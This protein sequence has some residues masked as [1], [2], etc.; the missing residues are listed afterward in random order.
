[1]RKA[2]PASATT[3]AANSS[4]SPSSSLRSE[5]HT[6][7]LQ[8]LTNIVCRLLLE[9]KKKVTKNMA[10]IDF[11]GIK[12]KV[13]TRKEIP[14]SRASQVLKKEAIAIIGYDVQGGTQSLEPIQ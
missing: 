12:E 1:M 14:L 5:E 9:K 7:E 6:S 2:T 3:A 13:I 10:T 11:G 4:I 8:S